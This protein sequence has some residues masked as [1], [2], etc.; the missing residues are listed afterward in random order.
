MT[1][2]GRTLR[3]A[4]AMR[5]GVSLSVWIGGAVHEIDHVRRRTLQAGPDTP[6][7]ATA[8]PLDADTAFTNVIQQLGD[9]AA[10]EIDVIAGT[11][12]GG[13]NGVLLA[14][15][16]RTGKELDPLRL[17]WLNAADLQKIQ[18]PVHTADRLSLLDGRIFYNTLCDVLLHQFFEHADPPPEGQRID[19]LLPVTVLDGIAVTAADDPTTPVTERRHD[20][21][22]HIRHH[23]PDPTWSDLVASDDLDQRP[24][25]GEPGRGSP[26]HRIVSG[27]VRTVRG[28]AAGRSDDR[29][30]GHAP[31]SRSSPALDTARGRR[32]ARQHPGGQSGA[33]HRRRHR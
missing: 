19:L 10:I 31:H 8:S 9:V 5:G 12:A 18:R 2:P 15:A 3:L 16:L 27:R 4:L 24:D 26:L 29:P 13:L 23:G 11:S 1:A 32:R 33:G 6:A 14:S 22:V 7:A 30:Q 17:V 20:A 25:R 21:V 28:P